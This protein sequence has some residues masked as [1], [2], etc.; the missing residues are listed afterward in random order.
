MEKTIDNSSID[1][2]CFSSG[3]GIQEQIALVLLIFRQD[4]EFVVHVVGVKRRLGT[5]KDEPATI[6]QSFVAN[7]EINR[8]WMIHHFLD[9][10]LPVMR[11][12]QQKS[13]ESYSDSLV[14]DVG[15]HGHK[16]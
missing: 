3:H 1:I 5:G 12:N 2:I 4:L 11:W 13:R 16:P 14:E 10:F 15:D 6:T 9:F 8:H 7:F